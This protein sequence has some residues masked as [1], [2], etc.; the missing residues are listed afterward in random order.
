MAQNIIDNI[1]RERYTPKD[2]Q[3]IRSQCVASNISRANRIVGRIFEEAFRDVGISS[4]QFALLVSLAIAPGSSAGDIAETLGSDPSTVSRNTE[5][6]LKRALIK[7]EPGQDRRYR[8]YYLTEEGDNIVQSCVPR[9]EKAQQTA[10]KQ[11]GRS[12]WEDIRTRLL[13]LQP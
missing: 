3:A 8:K 4:H 13:Q 1:G 7:V 5:L 12:N 11:V 2:F 6:L 9:W 10:L